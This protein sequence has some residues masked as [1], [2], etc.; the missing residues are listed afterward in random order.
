M[1]TKTCEF[2]GCTFERKRFPYGGLEKPAV[3]EK[4]RFCS[5][6][7][8]N[9]A[10][11]VHPPPTGDR[12]PWWK[13]DA[14]LPTTKRQ[15]AQKSYPLG[16]C[17]DCGDPATDRHHRDGDTGNNAPANIAILCR[18][19]HMRIDGRLEQLAATQ[20]PRVDARPCINCGRVREPRALARGR[21]TAC[22][23]YWRRKGMERPNH[24]KAQA[25]RN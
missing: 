10:P 15:R 24:Q 12:S 11:G 19:C 23:D 6:G 22:A 14:A 17:Q 4:R 3:W 5:V 2:C 16:A 13:G 1:N 18:R 20:R 7:C 8:S 9:S 25:G 21:C